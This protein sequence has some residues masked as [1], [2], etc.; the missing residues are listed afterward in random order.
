[1]EAAAIFISLE[2][3]RQSAILNGKA[4]ANLFGFYLLVEINF[5]SL[6]FWIKKEFSY[7]PIALLM[8]VAM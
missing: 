4:L 2:N 5:D 7:N 1:M 3:A 8:V 6:F